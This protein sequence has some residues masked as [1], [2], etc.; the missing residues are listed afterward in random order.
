MV[1]LL[2]DRSAP[3]GG[4]WGDV[5]LAQW[6]LQYGVPQGSVLS[7]MLFNIYMKA[8]G[9]VTRSFGMHCHQYTDE[10]QL[11]FSFSSSSGEAVDVLNWCLGVAMD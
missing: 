1:L 5:A 11:Y 10:T 4:A 3:E 7:P 2:L 9:V 8:L 6:I